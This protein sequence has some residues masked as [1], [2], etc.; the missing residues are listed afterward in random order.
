MQEKDDILFW[1]CYYVVIKE[2]NNGIKNTKEEKENVPEVL[3]VHINE[4][5]KK[6]TVNYKLVN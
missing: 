6:L 5:Y 3:N 1:F 4:I 2:N